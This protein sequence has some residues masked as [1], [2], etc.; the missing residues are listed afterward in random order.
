MEAIVAVYSDWGIGYQGSQPIVLQADRKFFVSKTAGAAMIVGRRTLQDFPQGCPLPGRPAIVL[1]RTLDSIS[2]A[3][4]VGDVDQ[5]IEVSKQYTRTVVAGGSSI[6][7]QLLQFCDS[8]YVTKLDCCPRS[9]VFFPNLDQD[10]DWVLSSILQDGQED[11]VHYSIC[12]YI[13][14]THKF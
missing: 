1:T 12:K 2:G 7:S 5:A 9:D 13:K 10:D 4:I 8:V 11:G 6:Y 14:S 3:T